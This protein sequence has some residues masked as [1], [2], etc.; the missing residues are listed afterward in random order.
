[1]REPS[2]LSYGEYT[3][4]EKEWR[5]EAVEN[6]ST[7]TT[8]TEDVMNDKA[9]GQFIGAVGLVSGLHLLHSRDLALG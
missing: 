3:D 4:R 7:G 9:S 1:M 2:G 5:G 8:G 6:S